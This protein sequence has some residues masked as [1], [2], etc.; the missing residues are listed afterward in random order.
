MEETKVIDVTKKVNKVKESPKMISVEQASAQV[1]QVVKQAN[2]KITQ[3]ATQVQQLETL[4][5]DHTI[6]NMFKV[7]EYSHHFEPEFVDKC[8]NALTDYLTQMALTESKEEPA[9]ETE[10]PE[11]PE[12]EAN[13]EE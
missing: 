12:S 1:Q 7:I 2:A 4:L 10:T 9:K 5:R 8:V 11:T 3:L 13:K 6:D